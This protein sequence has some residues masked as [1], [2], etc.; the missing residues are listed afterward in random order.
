[1]PAKPKPVRPEVPEVTKP[2]PADAGHS[3]K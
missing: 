3:N 2:K 1:V